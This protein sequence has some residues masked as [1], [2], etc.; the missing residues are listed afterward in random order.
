MPYSIA[1]V[2][3]TR[4][5]KFYITSTHVQSIVCFHAADVIK[6]ETR[7]K[8]MFH[9]MMHSSHFIYC[10]M[11]LDIWSRTT[12]M[13]KETQCHHCNAYVFRLTARDPLPYRQDSMYHNLWYTSCGVLTGIINSPVGKS[14][15]KT[16]YCIKY[17]KF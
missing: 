4:T 11:V 5:S 1:K 6:P 16:S 8:H 13:L 10:Y 14:K 7:K 3:S 17:L 9:L 12:P 2:A 15:K